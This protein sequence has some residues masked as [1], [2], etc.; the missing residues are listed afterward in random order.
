MV[1]ASGESSDTESELPSLESHSGSSYH[2][3]GNGDSDSST[4]SS[5]TGSEE[6]S[7]PRSAADPE[8]DV[9]E[10]NAV[11]SDSSSST[12]GPMAL[13]GDES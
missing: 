9:D 7:S 3:G 4:S 2:L 11:P 12:D 10:V 1:T 8:A 13:V 6:S 5:S